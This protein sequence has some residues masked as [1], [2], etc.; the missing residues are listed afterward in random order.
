MFCHCVIHLSPVHRLRDE[1]LI[2]RFA[3]GSATSVEIIRALRDDLIPGTSDNGN[4]SGSRRAEFARTPVASH[5][6]KAE[7]PDYRQKSSLLRCSICDVSYMPSYPI[8]AR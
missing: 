6:L 4:D 1:L 5:P 7:A 8:F 3:R 2:F